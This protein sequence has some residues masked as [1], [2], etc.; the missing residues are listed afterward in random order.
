MEPPRPYRPLRDLILFQGSGAA[1]DAIV[2]LALAGTLFFSVPEATARGRVALYLALTVAP[3]AVIAPLLSRVLDLHRAALRWAL[4]IAAVGRGALAW[5]MATRLESL[6]LFPLAFGILLLSRAAT[7]VRG[8]VLPHLVPEEESLVAANASLTRF[9]AVAGMVAVGPGLLVVRFIGDATVL[10]LGAVVYAL[11]VLPAFRL[12][13]PKGRR[14]A[15]ETMSARALARSV[16][17]RQATV[18]SAGMRFLVGFLVFHLA[19]ALRREDTTSI[20][21]GLLIAAAAVGGLVAAVVAPALRRRMR[22]EP[23]IVASLVVAGAAGLAVGRWFS[24]YAAATLVF[25]IGVTSGTAK[26]AFDSIVQRVTPEGGRGWAFARFESILQLSWVG[27]ALLPLLLPIPAGAG[28][29][30]AGVT[31][32]VLAAVYALGR[33]TVKRRGRGGTGGEA[34]AEPPTPR[35]HRRPIR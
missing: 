11:G 18:A 24:L 8:A 35:S 23:I 12:P 7:V 9:S 3:F 2:A 25:F 34:P 26:L 4:L 10:I 28:V 32:G 29:A 33:A 1:G 20:G 16:E 14:E 22:E 30:G 13:A 21:L 5:T 15:V 17:V 27:G 31:A 6:Y 19:F